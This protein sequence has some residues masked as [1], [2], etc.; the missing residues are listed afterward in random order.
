MLKLPIGWANAGVA[1]S[2]SSANARCSHE[3]RCLFI[4]GLLPRRLALVDCRQ[5]FPRHCGVKHME[6]WIDGQTLLQEFLA[7]RRIA[8]AVIDEACMKIEQRVSRHRL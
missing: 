5:R 6:M 1:A 3:S 7:H 8:V 2:S 4:P